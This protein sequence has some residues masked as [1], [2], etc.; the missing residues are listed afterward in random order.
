MM[1]PNKIWLVEIPAKG[2]LSK[3]QCIYRTLLYMD[4]PK[5]V[6]KIILYMSF[7]DFWRPKF[8]VFIS[9]ELYPTKNTNL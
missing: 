2:A 6:I 8:L 7:P 4:T 3:F 5:A 1:H 9:C